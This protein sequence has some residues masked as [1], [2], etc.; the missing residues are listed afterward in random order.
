MIL[1]LV[2]ARVI[3]MLFMFGVQ[4]VGMIIPF[5]LLGHKG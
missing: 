3:G 1:L 4:E 5:V 2:I